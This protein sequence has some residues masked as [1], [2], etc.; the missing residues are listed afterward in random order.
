V[1]FKLGED[2]LTLDVVDK[3]LRGNVKVEIS[4]SQREKLEKVRQF[5]EDHIDGEHTYYG[6]NTGFG[7]LA[8]EKIDIKQL[9]ELQTN[10]IRSHAFGV[11][12][13]MSED[14]VRLMTLLR[15]HVIAMGYSGASLPVV[16]LLT[17]MVNKRVIPVVPSQGS[18]GAS[19]D[20]APLSY[21][22]LAMIGE[23]TA[24]FDGKKYA[25]KEALKKAGLKPVTLQAKD[26]LT[27]INGTQA[28]TALAAIAVLRATELIKLTD[29]SAA[30]SVE[31]DRGSSAPF[32]KELHKVRAQ[33]G[34][35][36]SA[37][38]MRGL[39]DGSKIIEAHEDCARVQDPYSLRCIPQVHGAV[40][41]AFYYA[42]E[43]VSR[44]LNACTDNPLVFPESGKI[45]SG[46]NFHG[47]PLAVSMDTLGIAVAELGSIAEK[48]I[49]QLTNPKSHDLPV[50]FLTP[51]PGLNSGFMV[52][53]VVAASLA[54]ENKTLAHPA[55][56]DT[57][58]T[59]GGQED[60]VSMGMWAVRKIH[61]IIQNVEWI[62][63]IEITA[64]CQAIDLH[65]NKYDPGKGTKAAY[66]FVRG[67]VAYLDQDRWLMPEVEK[68]RAAILDG[69]LVRSVEKYLGEW[70]I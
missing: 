53:H 58:T 21:L 70:T 28:M 15:A 64:A 20:L 14:S 32:D 45:V 42:R 44:E 34:Q 65:E 39:L 43:V 59:S 49:E 2:Q 68:L 63:I 6:I 50:L 22:A 12:E 56:V 61:Q 13:S 46:G 7:R 57:L 52:P 47:E 33:K 66:G 24:F 29:I 23:G 69:G 18:V 30:L 41:D 31:G 48:R 1:I 38:T 5:V 60:H 19:G 67:H 54:S 8:N 55:S 37:K 17:N 3:F 16:D 35:I 26:G 62:N 9:E 10:L 36:V 40:R 4:S 27:L 25:A 11:G 51:K